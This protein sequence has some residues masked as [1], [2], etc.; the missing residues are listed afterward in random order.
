MSVPRVLSAYRKARILRR[1]RLP[2]VVAM[3]LVFST[4]PLHAR[5]MRLRSSKIT[6][7][8]RLHV[9]TLITAPG[10]AELDWG[11]LYS[12]TSGNYTM[13]SGFRY[14]PEG[15]NLLWG[16]TEYSVSFDSLASTP[17]GS[18]RLN[19]F[20]QALTVAAV[21][22]LHDGPKFDFA[23]APQ[24]T[25]FLRDEQGSRLGGVAIGRYDTG[26]NSIG[27]TA[28]WS[29]ATHS[30]ANNPAGTFDL[31]LGFGRQ[32]SGSHFLEHLTPH[33]N[34]EFEKSTGLTRGFL[35]SEGIELQITD[36]LAFDVSG[37]HFRG[38]G[39]PADNQIAFGLTYNLG[40]LK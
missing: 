37:Q 30:S 32:L 27:A 28:S 5:S 11:N 12:F 18:N 9:N 4:T 35:V 15:S 38:A 19:Q 13:P 3:L 14:T 21:T 7:Q 17:G 34:V 26:R 29:G 8:K 31:S 40:K 24:A 10:T 33:T 23:V 20:G 6:L 36:Q 1:M 22:V 16:R 39:T 25:F 2:L